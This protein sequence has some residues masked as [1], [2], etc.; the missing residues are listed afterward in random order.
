MIREQPHFL[1]GS[2]GPFGEARRYDYSLTDS[3]VKVFSHRQESIA[4]FSEVIDLINSDSVGDDANLISVAGKVHFILSNQNNATSTVNEIQDVAQSEFGWD[5]ST[6]E[7]KQVVG[8][9][10]ILRLAK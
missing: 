3:G 2:S 7:I 8:Y 6:S 10:Q 1:G 9:L 4:K 5:I